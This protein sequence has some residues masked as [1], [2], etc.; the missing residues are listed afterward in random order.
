MGIDEFQEWTKRAETELTLAVNLGTRGV[1]DAK[2]LLSTVISL[3]GHS[4]AIS[5]VR[6]VLKAFRC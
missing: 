1:E 3:V 5:D 4:I 6:M 2:T